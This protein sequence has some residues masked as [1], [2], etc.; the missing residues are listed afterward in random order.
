MPHLLDLLVDNDADSMLGYVV[1]SS[2]LAMVALVRHSFLNGTCALKKTSHVTMY[3]TAMIKSTS[4]P[5]VPTAC[6]Q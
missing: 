3:Y 5:L 4:L 1:Y 6:N 2:C